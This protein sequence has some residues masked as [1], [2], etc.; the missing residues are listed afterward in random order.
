[1]IEKQIIYCMMTDDK[2]RRYILTKIT[3]DYFIND[4]YKI[5]FKGIQELDGIKKAVDP[6]TLQKHLQLI[7]LEKITDIVLSIVPTHNYKTYVRE[8]QEQKY[9]LDMKQDAKDILNSTKI[10]EVID[11]KNKIS[12]NNFATEEKHVDSETLINDI[13]TEALTRRYNKEKRTELMS[14]ISDFDKTLGG[15]KKDNLVLIAA[16]PGV[17]K[18]AFVLN[19]TNNICKNN[20]NV[21]FFSLEMGASE[22]MKRILAMKNKVNSLGFNTF[23]SEKDITKLDNNKESDAD[24]LKTL[25]IYDDANNSIDDIKRIC[26]EFS[27]H[28]KLDCVIIDYLQLMNAKGFKSRNEEVGYLS[29]ECKKLAKQYNCPVLLLSQLSR[30]IESR[31]DWRP[32]LSDLRDSGSI[33]Q[34][35]DSVTFLAHDNKFSKEITMGIVA[36]NRHG[37]MRQFPML[38][39]KEYSLMRGLSEK[40]KIKLKELG[41]IKDVK[42]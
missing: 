23:F 26:G 36:K 24:E 22:L 28:N 40:E 18:T 8:L 2:A 11:I 30:N 10:D 9:I 21:L 31:K 13:I 12:N 29:R 37:E 27:Q 19:I 25:H 39:E 17:G 3:E 38:F 33:E 34:D 5:L 35:A 20:K 15:L 14:G 16:R 4:F 41:R 1:M 32:M 6:L 42:N 7:E